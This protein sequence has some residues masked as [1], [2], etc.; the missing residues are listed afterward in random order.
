LTT[1]RREWTTKPQW[2]TTKQ[3]VTVTFDYAIQ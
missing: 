3:M 2:T 1:K